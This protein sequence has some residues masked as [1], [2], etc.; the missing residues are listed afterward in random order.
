MLINKK[1]FFFIK[2]FFKNIFLFYFFKVQGFR[3]HCER[4]QRRPPFVE[5]WPPKQ[6]SRFPSACVGNKTHFK[7]KKEKGD[8]S[9]LLKLKMFFFIITELA[10]STWSPIPFVE[11]LVCDALVRGRGTTWL[12]VSTTVNGKLNKPKNFIKCG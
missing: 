2:F 10:N 6:R 5:T 11:T 8:I 1:F 4:F 12:P 7:W 9:W 3:W